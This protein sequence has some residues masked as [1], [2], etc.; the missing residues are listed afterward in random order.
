MKQTLTAFLPGSFDPPTNGHL[1]IIQRAH[2]LCEK[3]Y[4]GIAQNPSKTERLFSREETQA[5]LTLLVNELPRIEILSFDGL[6]VDTALQIGANCLIRGIRSATDC[7]YEFRMA[8]ANRK[9]SNLDTL[10]LMSDERHSHISSSLIRE[11]G[12]GGRELAA[13]IPLQI[14]EQVRRRLALS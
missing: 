9:V 5:L 2:A 6:A 14:E 7:E 12:R 8:V 1:D 10:F 11:L 13:F 4:V 3:L